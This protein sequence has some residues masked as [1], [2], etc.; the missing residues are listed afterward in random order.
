[1]GSLAFVATLVLV[2]G[3]PRGLPEW[4]AALGGGAAMLLLGI[5]PVGQAAGVLAD[6]LNVFGFF[7]GLMAISA[8][9]ETA[10]FF[11][12]LARLAARLSG[13]S[14]ARLLLNIMLIGVLITTFLTNDA[15]ALILTPLVY[16][17]VV[18]LRLSPLPYMFGCTFI[19]DTASF[20][21]PVSNPINVLVLTAFPRDLGS[22]LGHLLIP[23]ILVC[24]ANIA[25]FLWIFRAELKS[26]FDKGLMSLA[27]EGEDQTRSG[28]FRFVVVSLGGIA[29]VYLLA[30]AFRWPLAFVAIGGSLWLLAGGI[31][32]K[33][34]VW[35]KLAKEISWPIFGF[36]A[37][38]LVLVQ[39]IENL[40]LTAGFGRWLVG[41]S[42]G[43]TLGAAISSVVG[44]AI[45]SNAIN[46]VPM[47]LVLISSIHSAAP[48]G[49]VQ[50]VFVYGTI[51]GADLGPNITTVGSLATMLWLIILRR[52]GLEVSPLEYFR[53]GIVVTPILLFIAI[54]ALWL[55][56]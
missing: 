24:A 33:R 29:L 20:I 1:M 2:I 14:S 18:R 47:A 51:V 26:N 22:Y 3:R 28:Y 9:A 19:A 55:S 48:V 8:L 6:N 15:T 25:L 32:A 5:V 23:A 31:A 17:L 4:V 52:K 40:G 44:A 35:S 42:G 38:M 16:A 12:A 43:N 21:L 13:G 7:L 34:V 30:S 56:S 39:G 46:N 11:D 36:I 10:G 50:D 45:G 54:A 49:H 27:S 53:L 37:G 41:L